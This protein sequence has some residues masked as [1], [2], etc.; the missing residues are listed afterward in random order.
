M[1]LADVSEEIR[2][3]LASITGLRR[4]AWGVQRVAPPAA[5]VALPERIDY[6]ETYGRGKDRYPD[7]PLVILVGAPEARV[8]RKQ[9]AAY[10]DGVGSKSVKACLEAHVWVACESVRVAWAEFDA[11]AQYAGSPMLAAIFHLDIIGKGTA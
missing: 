9:V 6:D 1:N 3:T 10:T 7:L 5:L 8:S 11:G 4:P 2:T